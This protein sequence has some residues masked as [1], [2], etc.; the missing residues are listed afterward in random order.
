MDCER[1]EKE[2]RTWLREEEM[3]RK[4]YG[5]SCACVR[6]CVWQ[7]AATVERMGKLRILLVGVAADADCGEMEEIE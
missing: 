4:R 3:S 6:V 7:T 2:S 5:G 1:D